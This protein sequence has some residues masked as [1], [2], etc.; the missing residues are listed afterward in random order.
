MHRKLPGPGREQKRIS[1]PKGDRFE[2]VEKSSPTSS[3]TWTGDLGQR[4]PL[5][6][7]GPPSWVC[8]G[9]TESPS[10]TRVSGKPCATQTEASSQDWPSHAPFHFVWC[11][12]SR[13]KDKW[14]LNLPFIS[15]KLWCPKGGLSAGPQRG[16]GAGQERGRVCAACSSD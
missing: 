2:G 12:F 8:V 10:R 14:G 5:P 13:E 3:T 6:P 15:D 4:P 11:F 1:H 16:A 9:S 7:W